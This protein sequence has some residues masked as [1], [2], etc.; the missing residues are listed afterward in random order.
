MERNLNDIIPPS[1]RKAMEGEM[2][3]VDTVSSAP[4]SDYSRPKALKIRRTP[5]A[6]G[7]FPVGTAIVALVVVAASAGALYA[8]SKAKVTITPMQKPVTVAGD[9]TATSGT[10]LLPFQLI[11]VD[12]TASTEVKSEGTVNVQQASQGSIVISNTQGIVQKL[13]KNTRFE[14]A[15]GRIFR[16]HDS[17]AIPAGKDGAPG[18]LTVTVYADASG[19]SFNIPATTFKLPGLK[20]SKA[21]EQVV[22]KSSEAMSGGYSGPRP[23]V[24]QAT[25]DKSYESLRSELTTEIESAISQ[26]IPE[27]YV[28]VSGASFITYIAEPDAP[29]AGGAVTLSL[30]ATATVVVFP[31]KSLAAA[32]SYATDGSFNGQDVSLVGEAGLKL[33]SANGAAPASTDQEFAFKLEGNATVLWTVEGARIAGAVAGKDRQSAE[34][35][36]TGFPE[37]D[38]AKILIRPFWSSSFP[39][40]PSRI[41]VV[42]LEPTIGT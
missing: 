39:S 37:V 17:I 5:R 18:T 1:R 20:G 29:A 16:I 23:S 11:F 13:I 9:F 26:K 33:T 19:E 6:S 30:K 27:G 36:L 38:T 25:K 24:A 28:L 3:R 12:K 22:A 42:V 34:V 2:G 4:L 41:E 31:S 10:G 8:F 21:Y 32:I 15:D 14:S 7:R 35:A 40:D